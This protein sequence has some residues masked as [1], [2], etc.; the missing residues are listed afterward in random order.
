[1]THLSNLTIVPIISGRTSWSLSSGPVLEN[2]A[3]Q[4]TQYTGSSPSRFSHPVNTHT[5]WQN[6]IKWL[7]IK[8]ESVIR[9]Q[10]FSV[11]SFNSKQCR[12]WYLAFYLFKFL[13]V[14][15]HMPQHFTY[16]FYLKHI[17]FALRNAPNIK[18]WKR[19][20]IV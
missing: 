20:I 6:D 4:T 19:I 5:C 8:Y 7:C 11:N 10:G 1:M 2:S 13:S 14:P 18:M 9:W 17:S 15:F 3:T 16:S 12:F